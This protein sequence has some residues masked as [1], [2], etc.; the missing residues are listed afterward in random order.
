LLRERVRARAARGAD[1]SEA[2]EAVLA[3]QMRSAEPL[4]AD[5]LGAV[6]RGRPLPPQAESGEPQA[7][8]SALRQRLTESER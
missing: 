7:D 5:E 8:W 4:R 6:V 3:A 1:A 2:D